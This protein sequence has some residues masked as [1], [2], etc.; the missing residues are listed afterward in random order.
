MYKT[1]RCD[2]ANAVLNKSCTVYLLE[3][4]FT[5]QRRRFIPLL[6]FAFFFFYFFLIF[7][8]SYYSF[9]SVSFSTVLRFSISVSI[10]CYFFLS[11]TLP[12]CLCLRRS[13]RYFTLYAHLRCLNLGRLNG[14]GAN[15]CPNF[16]NG[17]LWF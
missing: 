6:L 9:S 14:F 10:F 3:K 16:A 5:V 13:Q 11:L 8:A 1:V 17:N 7:A 4:G 12:A 2:C 15:D